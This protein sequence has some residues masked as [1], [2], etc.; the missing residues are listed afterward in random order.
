M[1]LAFLG[2]GRMGRVVVAQARA[3]GY[4]VGVVLSSGDARAGPEDLA[5]ALSGHDVAIDFTVADAVLSH[6]TACVR[7]GVPLVEGTTAWQAQEAE[8]RRVVE[9][10]GG[11]IV[12][13]ANFS[14][15]VNLFYRLVDRA[16][17]LFRGMGYDAY[18][19]EAH[20]AKKRDAPSGTALELRRLLAARLGRE[21]PIASTRAGHILGVHRMGLDSVAD[22]VIVT[23]TARSRE[24]F[25]A[26]ALAA[27]RWLAGS[28]KRGAY[29]FGDVLD[30]ILEAERQGKP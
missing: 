25:G 9:Q 3:A 14:I 10:G 12:Y 2:N 11:A 21:V 19:E 18:I 7:A 24:S 4:E 15:G 5:A 13:G 26:G 8:V 16:G 17:E 20:H 27:A 29:A 28:G 6:A 23:H 30:E 22:E 1:R